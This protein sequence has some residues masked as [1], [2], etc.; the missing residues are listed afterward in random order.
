M[1]EKYKTRRAKLAEFKQKVK[2]SME[3]QYAAIVKEV[4]FSSLTDP[5]TINFET[6]MW[7]SIHWPEQ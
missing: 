7:G 2:A 3:T 1:K 6:E 5:H 4:M